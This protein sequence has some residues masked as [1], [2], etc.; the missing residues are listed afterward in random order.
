MTIDY[1]HNAF[2]PGAGTL[3]IERGALGHIFAS[4]WQTDTAIGNG[5]WGYRKDNTYKSAYEVATTLI[6]VVSKNGMLLLNIGPKP[7]G[8]FTDEE[9]AVL[10][11]TGAWL[12]A[13]GEGIYDTV[14]YKWYREGEHKAA[15][16]MFSEGKVAYDETDFR[17]TYKDGCVY[18]FQMKPA[19]T[20]LVTT[21]HTDRCGVC[22]K[23]VEVLG[24]NAV[25]RFVCDHN[26]LYIELKNEPASAM[27]QCFKITLA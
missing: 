25:A 10:A 6:D 27:P 7:D 5:S 26:G 18:A 4:P 2:A 8:T 15:S 11:D 23:D 21:L 22:V 17:F 20:A 13:N 1:K 12:R 19:Q 24:N 9:T 16:G 14:P 3:D